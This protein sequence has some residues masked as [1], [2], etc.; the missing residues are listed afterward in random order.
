METLDIPTLSRTPPDEPPVLMP[1]PTPILNLPP[2]DPIPRYSEE[3]LEYIR[4]KEKAVRCK[5]ISMDEMKIPFEKNTTFSTKC[6]KEILLD[7]MTGW[8]EKP[9]E[10]VKEV[11]NKICV[12]KMLNFEDPSVDY[13]KYAV[14]KTRVPE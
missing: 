4:K 8:F 1:D 2:D 11:F 3:Q 13:T 12:T 10:E 6:E 7:K 14:Y 9:D 5:I